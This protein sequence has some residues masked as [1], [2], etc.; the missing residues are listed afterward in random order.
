[1]NATDYKM[2][3]KVLS[4]N[5]STLQTRDFFFETLKIFFL[6]IVAVV[7][8]NILFFCGD[9]FLFDLMIKVALRYSVQ[10]FLSLYGLRH[11]FGLKVK[12]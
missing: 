1:M 12:N 10:F 2:Q 3:N 8:T 5:N 6:F 11:N 9:D 4:Q 7:V